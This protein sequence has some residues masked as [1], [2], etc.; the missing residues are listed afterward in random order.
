MPELIVQGRHLQVSQG[1]NLLT[2]LQGADLPINWSCRAGHCHSCL[3]QAPAESIPAA[4]QQGLSPAQQ[5][6][7]WLLA[8]QCSVEQDM[9]LTLHD[10][11][12][13]GLPAQIESLETLPGDIVRLRLAPQRPLRYR[14]G[15]HVTLWLSSRLGRSYSLAS[16]P[17]DALLE[18]HI[19][20]RDNGAF[21]HQLQQ[22]CVG[23]TL[24]L[25]APGGHLCYDPAWHDRPLLLLA[26]GTGLAPLQALAR[27]ALQSGHS[28]GIN[29][30][31]WSAAKQGCYL[32][33]PLTD[34]AASEPQLHLNLRERAD[35]D[36]DLRSLRI[37]SRATL[38]LVC[39]GAE[40]TEQVRRP[41]FMAG[42]AGPQVIDESFLARS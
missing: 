37:R 2:A 36:A 41:L 40:F 6:E 42:L 5:A 31:H 35:L 28:G 12:S 19:Q 20:V 26:S 34:L 16:L 15:Q 17:G 4:A 29:L 9:H 13:D 11:A 38:A 27:D 21:S 25:G 24:Y 32:Q 14:A 18:F 10:P 39:G 3:I 23:Q 33:Q 8:C 7:G 22:A 1:D 30:W